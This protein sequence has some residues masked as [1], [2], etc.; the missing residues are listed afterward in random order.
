MP[1]LKPYKKGSDVIKAK[2]RSTSPQAIFENYRWWD[3]SNKKELTQKLFAVIGHLKQSQ[4]W[5]QYL[6][7]YFERLYANLPTQNQIGAN[8]SQIHQQFRFPNQRSSYNVIASMTDALVSKI[9]QSRPKPMFCTFD[10]S[11]RL[12]KKAKDLNRFIEGELYQTKAY[13][14]GEGVARDC[15]T[16]GDGLWK[17]GDDTERVVLDRVLPTEIWIDL[18]DGEYGF[19]RSLHHLKIIDRDTLMALYPKDASAIAANQGA[20]FA[21]DA[22][23]QQSVVSM[24]MLAESWHLPSKKGAKDGLHV[25]AIDNQS[26]FDEPY[27]E[28][29][30]PF[31]R[32]SYAPRARG[33]WSA[34]IPERCMGLQNEI[35]RLLY[36]VQVGLYLCA[37]PKWLIEDG[38]DVVSAHINNSIG[39]QIKYKGVPPQLMVNGAFPPEVYAQLERLVNWAYQQEGVSQLYAGSQK[40]PGLNAAAAMREFDDIQSDRFAAF[41]KR[42]E[43]AYLDLSR[44][45]FKRAKYLAEK[46]GKYETI[47]P[48]KRGIEKID[49][50][51]LDFNPDD[52]MMRSS[53]VSALTD[54]MPERTQQVIEW[55]QAGLVDQEEGRRLAEF[56]DLEAVTS[57]MNAPRERIL[58]LLDKIVEDGEYNPPDSLMAPD[59]A[60]LLGV[61]Y[62]NKY[63]QTDLE[64]ERLQMIL[65]WN[66]QADALMSQA[67]SAMAPP[68]G[69]AAPQAVPQAPPVSQ[70]LPNGAGV[71]AA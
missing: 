31:V 1:K 69:S 20:I 49:L 42:W 47:Y 39:S 38:S 51:S 46:N 55:M 11:P 33:Y 43:E 66:A 24:V 65:T 14:L 16:Q 5:R 25:I 23:S 60:K 70:M 56:P 28:E 19:P 59:Q 53:P 54:D 26:L 18:Q 68:P 30:F 13:A 37:I 48:G 44:K 32:L 71:R 4:N 21:Q 57:L 67:E 61:Q 36:G 6:A 63:A 62:Y 45:I 50:A 34:G 7:S 35:N 3:A 41:Q 27:E 17:V 64:P 40:P 8:L 22:D 58:K 15:I 52:F 10:G 12:Q 2:T 29:D 9:S